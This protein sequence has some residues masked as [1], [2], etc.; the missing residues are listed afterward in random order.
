VR[1]RAAL[2]G[3][4]YRPR[5]FCAS[6]RGVT[7]RR[8]NVGI[9]SYASDGA[10]SYRAPTIGFFRARVAKKLRRLDPKRPG[11]RE[12][13]RDVRVAPIIFQRRKDA[14]VN[15]E[16]SDKSSSVSPERQATAGARRS[17]VVK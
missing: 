3:A 15:P 6:P 11:D 7:I 17:R 1:T 14:G 2:L 9:A 4:A 8:S 12:Q 10:R 5:F 16:R 13:R